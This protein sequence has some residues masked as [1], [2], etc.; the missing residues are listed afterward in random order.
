MNRLSEFLDSLLIV[1]KYEETLRLYLDEQYLNNKF[2][3]EHF[4][5]EVIISQMAGTKFC[6][7]LDA[8]KA[9]WQVQLSENSSKLTSL[10]T[11]L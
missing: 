9:F 4:H 7:I 2:L 10:N 5:F 1:Q 11:P 8:D 3:R 6:S